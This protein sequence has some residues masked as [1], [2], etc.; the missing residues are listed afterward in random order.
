MMD[1]RNTF[2]LRDAVCHFV[3]ATTIWFQQFD[4]IEVRYAAPAD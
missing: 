2:K 1:S 4:R 3:E